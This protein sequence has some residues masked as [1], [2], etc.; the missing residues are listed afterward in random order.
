SDFRFYLDLNRNGRFDRNGDAPVILTDNAGKARYVT[1]NGTL[2]STNLPIPANTYLLTNYFV[3][4]PEWIGVLARPQELHSADNQFISRYAY[5]VVPVGKTLD[6]NT[7]HN[8]AATQS[9]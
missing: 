1:T 7:M 9:V 8:Q 2:V 4:D 5:L 3:G 6:V